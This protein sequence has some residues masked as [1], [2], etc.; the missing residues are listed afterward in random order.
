[1][2]KLLVVGVLTCGAIGFVACAGDGD[3]VLPS[4]T[5]PKSKPTAT[6]QNLTCAEIRA[7]TTTL[8]Q[9]DGSLVVPLIVCAD[10]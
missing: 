8:R 2:R 10:R 4:D 3:V 6:V 9:A 1:M 7:T 5:K